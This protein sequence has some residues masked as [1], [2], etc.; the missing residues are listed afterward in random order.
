MDRDTYAETFAGLTPA[1]V[2]FVRT[3]LED[4]GYQRFQ[5][6]HSALRMLGRPR[7]QAALETLVPLHPGLDDAAAV[8][9]L[10]PYLRARLVAATH[11]KSPVTALRDLLSLGKQGDGEDPLRAWKAAQERRARASSQVQGQAPAPGG[12][13]EPPVPPGNSRLLS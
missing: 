11:G 13:G 6:S 10:R 2:R 12:M 8:N 5:S 7:V 1:E 4:R 9:I 3:V